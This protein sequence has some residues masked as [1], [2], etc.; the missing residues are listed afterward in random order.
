[1]HGIKSLKKELDKIKNK[2]A[3]LNKLLALKQDKAKREMEKDTEKVK[4]T[5][6]KMDKVKKDIDKLLGWRSPA[7]LQGPA[8]G[9]NF[10]FSSP[11]MRSLNDYIS[12]CEIPLINTASGINLRGIYQINP[13]FAA[14]LGYESFVSSTSGDT[15]GGTLTFDLT[16]NGPFAIFVY[17][18]PQDTMPFWL[19]ANLE[20]G[21]YFA[22]YREKENGYEPTG[23]STATG[24]K[25]GVNAEYPIAQNTSF[26][27]G[28]SY[29]SLTFNEFT[30]SDGNEIKYVPAY[31][32][33]SATA[34]FSGLGLEFGIM[35]RL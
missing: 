34:D 12:W 15:A 27:F 29:R 18:I 19:S 16:A 32:D 22:R 10:S 30:D 2:L 9:C 11:V 23:T 13:L 6:D 21:S 35:V 20:I 24:F 17:N 1:M 25:I 5:E 28:T 8:F 7:P 31:G 33:E 4:E 14:G 3:L 26:V